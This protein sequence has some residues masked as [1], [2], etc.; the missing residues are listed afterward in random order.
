MRLAPDRAALV[1]GLTVLMCCVS[2]MLA[3][4]KLRGADPA[5]VF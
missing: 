2:G 4:R 3:M 5:E 1:L